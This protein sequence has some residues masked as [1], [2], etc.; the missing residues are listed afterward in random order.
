VQGVGFRP[1]VYRAAKSLGLQGYVLNKGSN[2]DIGIKGDADIEQFLRSL[3]NNLPPLASI[4]EIEINV[5]I[6]YHIVQGALHF[7]LRLASSDGD[8]LGW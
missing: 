4:D 3:T 5:P 6:Y 1:T 2:V 7:Y 8:S